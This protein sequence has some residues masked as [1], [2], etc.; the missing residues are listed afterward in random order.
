MRIQ[1]SLLRGT[2]AGASQPNGRGEWRPYEWGGKP[3][4]DP[5]ALG[6]MPSPSEE[7]QARMAE[8]ARL[9]AEG[10]TIGEAAKAVGVGEDAG[11]EYE[12]HLKQ[13]RERGGR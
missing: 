11:R 6:R 5:A 10:L 8:F 9:R 3:G 12:R 13:E 7:K 2:G 4:W 1:L